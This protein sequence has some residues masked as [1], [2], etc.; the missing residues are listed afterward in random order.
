MQIPCYLVDLEAIHMH[1]G[2]PVL[3]S[4]NARDHFEMIRL[5]IAWGSSNHWA[6]IFSAFRSFNLQ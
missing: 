2:E 3:L 4:Q 6:G 5:H 1:I